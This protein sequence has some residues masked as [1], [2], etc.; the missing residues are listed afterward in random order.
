MELTPFNIFKSGNFSDRSKAVL[1][2]WILFAI[3]VSC[4]SLLC[5]LVCSLRPVVTCWEKSDLLALLCVLFAYDLSLSRMV[6]RVRC[7]SCLY[8]SDICSVEVELSLKKLYKCNLGVRCS[9]ELLLCVYWQI[10]V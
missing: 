4:L 2:L 10:W 5:C 1:L 8:R 9:A 3:Y 6:L 7:G